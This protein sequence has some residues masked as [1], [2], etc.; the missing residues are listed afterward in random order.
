VLVGKLPLGNEPNQRD[1]FSFTCVAADDRRAYAGTRSGKLCVLEVSNPATPKV[2]GSAPI[3][4]FVSDGQ[5][6]GDR[7]FLTDSEGVK[8]FDV[9][10]P[11]G[12]VLLGQY[13]I[14]GSGKKVRVLGDRVFVTAWTDLII[15][16]TEAASAR[17]ETQ[18]P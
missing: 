7:V 2:L 16:Q 15:L 6:V 3:N 13:G 10:D 1:D 12:P 8:V 11:L 14:R 18:K 5:A 9:A 4:G 17:P